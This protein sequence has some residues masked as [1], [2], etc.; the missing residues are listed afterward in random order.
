MFGTNSLHGA[1][2]HEKTPVVRLLKNFPT[3]YGGCGFFTMFTTDRLWSLSWARWIQSI[4]P[5]PIE[6]R[7]LLEWLRSSAFWPGILPFFMHPPPR[8]PCRRFFTVIPSFHVPRDF[9]SLPCL[10]RKTSVGVGRDNS[11]VCLSALGRRRSLNC[12]DWS[13]QTVIWGCCNESFCLV[14]YYYF[15]G[16]ATA[17]FN[18]AVW[19]YNAVTLRCGLTRNVT[20][21]LAIF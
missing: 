6:P 17:A 8:Q 21:V 9:P 15:F 11:A 2:I 7:F 3:F 14:L 16:L 20:W 12:F 13:F 18:A 10:E 4:P 1:R 19:P 5:H